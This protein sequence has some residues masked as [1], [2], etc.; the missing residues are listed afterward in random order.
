MIADWVEAELA[1]VDLKHERRNQ[2]L[3]RLVSELAAKP[4]LSIPAAVGGG[5]AETAAAYR[6]FENPAVEF[7]AIL[8]PHHEATLARARQQATVILAQDTS[9][10]ELTR[11][12]QRVLGAGPLDAGARRGCFLHP[13]LAV[14]PE[15]VPLGTLWA[16]CWAREDA[17]PETLDQAARKRQRQQTPIEE[18]E[19]QRWIDGLREAHAVAARLPETEVI[20]VADSEADIYELLVAGQAEESAT[21][22]RRAQW[23]VRACQDRALRL[24][25]K[26][27]ELG[28]NAE[29]NGVKQVF[30]AVAATP[31]RA[32]YEVSVRGRE[33]KVVCNTSSRQQP[34]ESRQTLVEVRAATVTLRAP[35]R[36]DRKLPDVT[37]NAVLVR[38][39]APP[40]GEEPIEWLLLTSLPIGTT[41]E[42]LRVIQSYCQRWIIELF[43][44]VLKQGCQVE[45]R[46][47][48]YLDR[49]TRFL[50]VALIVAWRT[51]YVTRLG[52]D[53]PDLD[54]EAVFTPAEWKPV[55][56][57]T[58]KQRPPKRPP[59]L[60][61]MVRMVAQLGGYV[62][63]PRHDE[64]GAETIW[65]GLQRMHDM[66]LCWET[67]GPG[68]T[69]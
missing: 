55:Y 25:K 42:V 62:N 66:A 34:R 22:A 45:S 12:V 26:T 28:N 35:R 3:K 20:A 40:A 53:S 31:V 15:G 13:L 17:S 21:T 6:F 19:S 9:E 23:I 2:R 67:F 5:H 43:F 39:V 64:P 24:D 33:A 57:I 58:Q 7:D 51:L 63:R 49:V 46:R 60:Q 30:D 65:K 36:P 48:E 68:N 29:E 47:F 59:K 52:R 18:K 37:I 41:E 32:T 11:P 56:Q 61:A 50:A 8:A 44:R 69:G 16:R 10:L 4:A 38:E 1:T 14:T 27:E 54:C